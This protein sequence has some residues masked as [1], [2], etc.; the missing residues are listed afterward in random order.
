MILQNLRTDNASAG[1]KTT[2]NITSNATTHVS[3]NFK[4]PLANEN[5]NTS[6]EAEANL[7]HLKHQYQD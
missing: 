4:S 6:E 1:V 5:I 2:T 7:Q 3:A